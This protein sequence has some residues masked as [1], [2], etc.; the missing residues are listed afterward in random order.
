MMSMLVRSARD[1][2]ASRS[3]SAIKP[4][5]WTTPMGSSS[6][7]TSRSE[8]PLTHRN[9]PRRSN[10]SPAARDTHRAVTAARGYGQPS[11][12][13]DL[14]SLGVRRVAIPRASKPS[15][16]RREVEHRRA[17]RE[18]VKWRTGSEGRINH[19]KRSYGWNRTELTGL[20][21]ARTWCGHGVFAHNLLKIGTLAA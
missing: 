3:S 12:E 11:V 21:G 10:G 9:W 15:A 7:A 19:M 5:S 8:T 1:V 17:F 20:T 13:R 2:W 16:A 18:K 4:R 14:H 6:T